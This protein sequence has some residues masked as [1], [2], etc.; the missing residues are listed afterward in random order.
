MTR[1]ELTEY[2]LTWP[3]CFEDHPFDA[4]GAP[5][6]DS[7]TLI[8]HR[9]NRKAFA[10]IFER[11]GLCINLK[12]EPMRSGFLRSAL[13][14]GVAPAYHM[15]KEHWNTVRPDLVSAEDLEDLIRRSYMLTAPKPKL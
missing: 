4:P 14:P 9:K 1:K 2:C 12:C 6:A 15:N 7:W 10:F 3:D 5:E 11:D 8:R 13:A